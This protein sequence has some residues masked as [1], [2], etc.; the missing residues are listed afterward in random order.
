MEITET[1]LSEEELTEL[2]ELRQT[3]AQITAQIGRLNIDKYSIEDR[4]K[5]VDTEITK[6]RDMYLDTSKTE[7]ELVNKLNEKY[8]QGKIDLDTGV[9]TSNE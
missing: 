6:A 4:L 5:F 3:Y 9:F 7:E 8:G 1:K 2:S